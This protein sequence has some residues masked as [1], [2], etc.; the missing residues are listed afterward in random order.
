MT[1][2]IHGLE[3]ID[4]ADV[5]GL[6]LSKYADPT[7]D[8]REGLSADEARDITAEDSSLI[9]IDM[10]VAREL[11][12]YEI[13][14]LWFTLLDGRIV[15]PEY[16]RKR[17]LSHRLRRILGVTLEEIDG[18]FRDK[19]LLRWHHQALV[20]HVSECLVRE[21]HRRSGRIPSA[22]GDD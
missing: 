5:H 21:A 11:D 19:R 12:L 2:R 8:A 3:A 6:T 7:E 15:G 1:T 10:P 13:N 22:Y 17:V 14:E 18:V 9:Y 4:Y 20:P 16:L